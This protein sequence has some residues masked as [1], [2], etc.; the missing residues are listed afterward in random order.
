[1]TEKTKIFQ[2]PF[3]S[4]FYSSYRQEISLKKPNGKY[5]KSK[6]LPSFFIDRSGSDQINIKEY[7]GEL[8]KKIDNGK[9]TRIIYDPLLKRDDLFDIIDEWEER[10]IKSYE[11]DV[12]PVRRWLSDIGSFVSPTYQALFFDLEADPLKLGFDP[13]SKKEHR[14]ISFAAKDLE[15]NSWF[16]AAKES[17]NEEERKVIMKFLDVIKY[18]DTLLAWNGKDY[19]YFVLKQ[20]CKKLG[21][22]V[23]WSK[24]NLLDYLLVTKKLL[25]SIPDPDFKKSFALD[26]VGENILG[27][28]KI[29]LSVKMGKL[30]ELLGKRESELKRY[31]ERDVEIM[32]DVE[33]K[34]E[35][36]ALHSALCSLCNT[37]PG[38]NSIFP[39]EL[40]DGILLRLGLINNIHFPTRRFFQTE[41]DRQKY[42]GAFVLP[43]KIGFHK[44]VQVPDFASLYP[45]IILSWNMSNETKL[46]PKQRLAPSKIA[47]ATATGVRFRTDK[48]GIIP[49]ALDV[50]LNKRKEYAQKAKEQEVGS[51]E[52][53]NLNHL[54]TAVKVATNSFY[55]LIGS[56]S[57]RFYDLDIARS[58]TLTAQ[59]LI[60]KVIS[61]FET[62]GYEAVAGDTDSVFIKSSE[63]LMKVELKKING[64]FIPGILEESGCQRNAVRMDF[65]KGYRTLLIVTKKRYAGKLS[66]YKGVAAKEDAPPEI[67]GLETQ[68]SDQLRLTQ[69]LMK[70]YID[71]LLEI[72]VD[73]YVIDKELRND[74]QTFFHKQLDVDEVTITQSVGRHPDEY[75]NKGPHVQIAEQLIDKGEEFFV[76]M[77]IPYVV[78]GSN[79]VIKAI[80]A[81]DF[82]GQCDRYFYWQRRIL[83]PIERMVKARFGKSFSFPKFD[84]PNQYALDFSQPVQAPIV[85]KIHVRK[86]TR[87]I[88]RV[89]KIKVRKTKKENEIVFLIKENA[90]KHVLAGMKVLIRGFA[91]PNKVRINI[92]FHSSEGE[93]LVEIQIK[94]RI[95]IEGMEEIKNLFGNYITISTNLYNKE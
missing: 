21:I 64:Y 91:G 18:Y 55:G 93:A 22:K 29:K 17:S 9:Y 92:P 20:R 34:R 85:K 15:G 37:F 94:E 76:G 41:D 16:Y 26:S 3:V 42:E 79:P 52:W 31:N 45:S 56:E 77:K 24:W 82:T 33:K 1:M 10:G 8:I 72:D 4:A 84:D 49:T 61:Y 7:R 88:K 36:F 69:A 89:K 6:F 40:A 81:D 75:T 50:L 95:S 44:N 30:K 66:L 78:I 32:I 38:S 2:G 67:K 11:A 13:E 47:Y 74:G 19:D 48:I 23:Q 68:R 43:P 62:K 14:I 46:L 12:S 87:K 58:I 25:S 73:P 63:E 57:S 28:R 5:I 86:T 27:I 59:L 65:D 83:P 51:E 90:P 54:S 70:K 35:F 80:H 53:K 60:R 39:S 71:L